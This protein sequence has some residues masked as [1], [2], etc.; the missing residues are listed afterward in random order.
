MI[1]GL[2][3]EPEDM[4]NDQ[5]QARSDGVVWRVSFMTGL[6]GAQ[7]LQ[8]AKRHGDT[9]IVANLAEQV[10]ALV[11]H[12]FGARIILLLDRKIAK[13][14]EGIAVCSLAPNPCAISR[15]SSR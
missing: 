14:R 12:L 13:C 11:M 10:K 7:T 2:L 15:L 3:E 8:V 6:V 1:V 4:H 5:S 9:C